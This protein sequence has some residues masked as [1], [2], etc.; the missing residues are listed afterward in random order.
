MTL[1][2]PALLVVL[3]SLFAAGPV[4][5]APEAA[6]TPKRVRPF[7]PY[8]GMEPRHVR[9]RSRVETPRARIEL[10]PVL[11]GDVV[12]HEFVIANPGPEPME[13]EG[14]KM[15]SGCI[16]GGHSKRI[17][18]GREGGI[19]LLVPTDWLGGGAIASPITART[20]RPGWETLRIDVA[21]QVREFA[22]L[23][24]YRVWLRGSGA[25]AIVETCW[26][27][28]NEAYPFSITGIRARKGIWFSHSWREVER[29]GRRAYE[30]T[31]ENTRRK[32]GPYQDVLFVQTDH[33]ERPEFRIRIEGRIE[34]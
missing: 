16:L 20:T 2:N 22:A 4:P 12:H 25:E 28:P 9:S 18:P 1:R 10:E 3:A 27:V 7:E 11:Q 26:V 30:I 17:E 23:S 13:I 6:A 33:P 31:I 8:L 21:L 14:L 32:V 19:R 34:E 24:P 29:D 5:A 15:C